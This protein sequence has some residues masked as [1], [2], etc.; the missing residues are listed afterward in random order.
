MVLAQCSASEQFRHIVRFAFIMAL[1]ARE[2]SRVGD[3]SVRERLEI[4]AEGCMFEPAFIVSAVEGESGRE[5][6]RHRSA[7]TVSA[8]LYQR[9]AVRAYHLVEGRSTPGHAGRRAPARRARGCLSH[10]VE[11]LL[12]G[13]LEGE[14]GRCW[15]R[16]KRWPRSQERGSGDGR[17][18]RSPEPS[19][20]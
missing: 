7:T 13:R 12:R 8:G 3:R 9:H 19:K 16:Q 20:L 17:A 4:V 1:T 10:D 15:S 2:S 18:D 11:S 5:S 14:A 6:P